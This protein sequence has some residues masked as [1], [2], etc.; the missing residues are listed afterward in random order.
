M[1]KDEVKLTVAEVEVKVDVK[2]KKPTKRGRGVVKAAVVA[3][4]TVAA[5]GDTEE[6]LPKSN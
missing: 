4:E 5:N 1:D 6:V 3:E 2:E